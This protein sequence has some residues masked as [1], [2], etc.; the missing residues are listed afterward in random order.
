MEKCSQC[1]NAHIKIAL[2]FVALLF[3]FAGPSWAQFSKDAIILTLRHQEGIRLD[4]T[5]AAEIDAG[6]A[7]ARTEIDT[8]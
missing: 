4:S 5:L 7:A 1:K 6:L 2:L 8:L 3:L